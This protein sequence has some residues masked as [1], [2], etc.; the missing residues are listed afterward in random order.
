MYK[1]HVSFSCK[2]LQFTELPTD[3][4]TKYCIRA[5]NWGT[6]FEPDGSSSLMIQSS[7][8]LCFKYNVPMNCFII[9]I[10]VYPTQP[11]SR[12]ATGSCLTC[13]IHFYWGLR[14]VE[15]YIYCKS[16]AWT[17]F[18]VFIEVNY[19]FLSISNIICFMDL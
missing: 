16:I 14:A 18:I 11:E 9:A 2:I 8:G 7:V 6:N 15:R 17:L 19:V 5:I 13:Y 4:I 12:S 1:N 3:L 10:S